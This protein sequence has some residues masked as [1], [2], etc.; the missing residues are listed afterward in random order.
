MGWCTAQWKMLL[1]CV[2]TIVKES[3]KFELAHLKKKKKKEERK[4]NILVIWRL[5]GS[6]LLR[7]FL[8]PLGML[9]VMKTLEDEQQVVITASVFEILRVFLYKH[10]LCV[11]AIPT[12]RVYQLYDMTL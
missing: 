4:K 1:F 7:C 2:K 10:I 9:F 6:V 8:A 12:Y 11:C 3:C 5:S